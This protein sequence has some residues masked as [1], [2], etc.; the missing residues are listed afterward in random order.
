M[1]DGL[2]GKAATME[3]PISSNGDAGSLPEDDGL[4]QDLQQVMV[5]G[6]NLNETSI[7][8]GGYG[9][10]AEGIIPTSA[11]KGRPGG[12][13]GAGHRT[14]RP[15]PSFW[16]P[17][18]AP[19]SPSSSSSAGLRHRPWRGAGRAAALGA[20]AGGRADTNRGVLPAA[21]LAP[22]RLSPQPWAQGPDSSP[23]P[24]L[25]PPPRQEEF[26]YNA[27]TQKLLCKNGETLLGAVN[28]F[29]SSI[30]TLV[31]KTMEDTLMTVKQYE[32][33]R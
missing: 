23:D 6:P 10:T 11:I 1:S 15:F 32:T 4:E 8:S 22:P 27:E 18:W 31:N 21:A 29:V 17:F 24:A 33:A 28:F 3:I 25:F 30:N 7:V 5:S 12:A 2:L 14:R 13:P 26:G 16:A 20:A 19:F 9:G